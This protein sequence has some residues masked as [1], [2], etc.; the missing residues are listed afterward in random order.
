MKALELGHIDW[1]KETGVKV[2]V[3]LNWSPGHSFIFLGKELALSPFPGGEALSA[4]GGADLGG[5]NLEGG[6]VWK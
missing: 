3:G 5:R 4:R 2:G 1:R 6:Q